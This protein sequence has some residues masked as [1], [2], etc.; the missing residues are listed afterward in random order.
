MRSPRAGEV[1]SRGEEPDSI[2]AVTSP[3]V[4]TVYCSF[5]DGSEAVASSRGVTK[6]L[7]SRAESPKCFVPWRIFQ[8]S[9]QYRRGD[10]T[11]DGTVTETE[12]H[13][14]EIDR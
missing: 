13:Q 5:L 4:C 9:E 11:I 3:T 10:V 7:T 1:V 12:E 6:C 2:L 8:R 14:I